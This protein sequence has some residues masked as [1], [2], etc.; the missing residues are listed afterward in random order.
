[1]KWEK[2]DHIGVY[3]Q[4]QPGFNY[5]GLHIPVGK[6]DA[7]DF[8]DLASLAEVYGTGEIRVTVEQNIIIAHVSDAKLDA[9]LTEPILQ[10]FSVNPGRLSRTVV[11]CTG[12]QFCGFA[13]IET[14]QY[15]LSVISAVEAKVSIDRPVR[16]HWTGCPNSCGQP[17]VADI[18]LMGSKGRKDGKIVEAVDIFTGGKVGKDAKLGEKTIKGV[19]IVDLEEVLIDLLVKDFGAQPSR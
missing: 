8:F 5:V 4:Q 18:G 14:K 2:R 13:L 3:P 17:Q 19:P 6:L 1:M 10:K 11:S 7:K 16:I 12:A 15:A 9:L